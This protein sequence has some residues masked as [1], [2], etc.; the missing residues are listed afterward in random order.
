MLIIFAMYILVGATLAYVVTTTTLLVERAKKKGKVLD[1]TDRELLEGT[2]EKHWV[3]KMYLYL[4]I[5]WL[6]VVLWG[7]Y[8]KLLGGKRK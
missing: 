4:M 2:D 8:E 3:I 5:F 7:L 6:P 1:S